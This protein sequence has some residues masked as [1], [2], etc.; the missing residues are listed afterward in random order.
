MKITIFGSGSWGTAVAVLLCGNGHDVT[1]WSYSSQ[2]AQL[3]DEKRENPLLP[4][5]II[6]D[7]VKITSDIEKA[8]DVIEAAVVATPSFA[9]A[10]TA[11]KIKN[12][13]S[14]ECI[15]ICISKGIEKDTS[16][17]F[18]QILRRELGDEALIASLS[19]P[20]HAE[21]VGRGMLTGCVAASERQ[22]VAEKV[23]DIFM[24][25][26]F[27]VYTSNDVVGVELGAAMKNVIALGAG[28]CDGMGCGDNTMAMLMTRGLAEMANLCI[29][30]GGKRETLLGLAGVGDL[31]VT[32]TSRHSRNRRAGVLIGKGIQVQEAMRQV[33]AVVEGYYATKAGHDL[34]EK[35]GVQMTIVEQMYKLLYEGKNVD[36][37]IRDLMAREKKPEFPEF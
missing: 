32:C 1:L 16:L 17:R 27:R 34:A 20:S 28:I 3:L 33:G 18:S 11:A 26:R 8:S 14:P 19:G 23:Q 31:I 24:N 30:L 35:T 9:V 29:A 25:E 37:C 6:P 2:E 10:Q 13:I 22:D 7:S 36:D 12:L 5:V 15:V 21:E 4:G